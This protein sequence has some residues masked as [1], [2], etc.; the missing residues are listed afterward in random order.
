MNEEFVKKVYE[1][2]VNEGMQTYK[3]L[4]INT[5]ITDNT[6]DYWKRTLTFYQSLEDTQKEVFFQIIK[7]TITD[8]VSGIFG[9]MDGSSTLIGGNCDISIKIDGVST[10]DELQ[11]DF[12]VFVEENQ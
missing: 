9:I 2:V 3:D 10:D 1:T 4:F 6:V 11:D 8:T 12:L 5:Q 7:Q